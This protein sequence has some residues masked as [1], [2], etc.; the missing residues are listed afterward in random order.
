MATYAGMLSCR[1]NLQSQKALVFL[2]DI[3]LTYFKKSSLVAEMTVHC[4]VKSRASGPMESCGNLSTVQSPF[5]Q[6]WC[7]EV[8]SVPPN[9]QNKVSYFHVCILYVMS[10]DFRKFALRFRRICSTEEANILNSQCLFWG[11]FAQKIPAWLHFTTLSY[12][13]FRHEKV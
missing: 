11:P 4:T 7:G 8:S 2:I 13:S 3:L 10:E 5:F 1:W 6:E 9:N 12:C